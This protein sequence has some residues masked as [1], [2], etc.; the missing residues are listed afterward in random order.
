MDHVQKASAHIISCVAADGASGKGHSAII[1][2]DTAALHSEKEMSDFNG[3][4]KYSGWDLEGQY[5]RQEPC[6]L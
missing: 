6:C 2:V 4:L 5:S 3:A 1:D